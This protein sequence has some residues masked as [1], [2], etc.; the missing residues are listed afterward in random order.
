MLLLAAIYLIATAGA[1]KY[2]VPKPPEEQDLQA[3][4]HLSKR[5]LPQCLHFFLAEPPQRIQCLQVQN[6]LPLQCRFLAGQISTP[7]ILTISWFFS[8]DGI[9]AQWV[10][11]A[12]FQVLDTNVAFLNNLTVSV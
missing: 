5:Q 2:L 3:Y 11:S 1:D 10:Q 7:Q 9:V 8:R 4:H 12:R 6:T